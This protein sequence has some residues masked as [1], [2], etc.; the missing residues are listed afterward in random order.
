M[1]IRKI[2]HVR[3]KSGIGTEYVLDGYY[4]FGLIPLYVTKRYC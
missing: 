1:I 3:H 4:L 2:K